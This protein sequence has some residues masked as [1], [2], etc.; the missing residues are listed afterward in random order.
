MWA[1]CER[2]AVPGVRVRSAFIALAAHQLPPRLQRAGP[3]VLP[4]WPHLYPLPLEL[5]LARSPRVE[6]SPRPCA[7]HTLG[8]RVPCADEK[9][10]GP[11][12]P[13]GL[14]EACASKALGS[15]FYGHWGGIEQPR[16]GESGV[17][18]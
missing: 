5:R 16:R 17:S 7:S 6:D 15:R 12:A 11:V 14:G 10:R 2:A 8:C 4:P 1:L 13:L 18:G 3:A 9:A